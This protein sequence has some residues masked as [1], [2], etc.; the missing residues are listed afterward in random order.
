MAR[1]TRRP[2]DGLQ[3][4][5]ALVV[6]MIGLRCGNENAA[7]APLHE[8]R[9]E[10]GAARAKAGKDF[11]QRPLQIG[12]SRRAGIHCLHGIDKDDLPV[13]PGDVL[14]EERLHH[15]GLVGFVT[16]LHHCGERAGTR[17]TRQS[18][19]WQWSEGKRRRTVKIARHQEAA[20]R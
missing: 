3:P 19:V 8:A 20:G 16:P 5:V 6:Q 4:V 13:E 17:L 2:D 9:Q 18:K 10:I 12:H 7:D 11:R 14:A 15:V 1:S